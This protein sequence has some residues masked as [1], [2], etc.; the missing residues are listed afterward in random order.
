VSAVTLIGGAIF[1][2]V[3]GSL[4]FLATVLSDYVAVADARR[5]LSRYSRV[6]QRT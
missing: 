6:R 3:G 1:R 5:T 2:F 4:S